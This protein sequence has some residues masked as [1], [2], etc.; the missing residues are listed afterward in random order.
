MDIQRR[1]LSPGTKAARISL[2]IIINVLHKPHYLRTLAKSCQTRKQK[3]HNDLS[4]R[5]VRPQRQQVKLLH[6]DDRR[7]D[8]SRRRR[9]SGKRQRPVGSSVGAAILDLNT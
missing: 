4:I 6:L 3:A 9:C 7:L 5:Q 8:R 1:H 2:K